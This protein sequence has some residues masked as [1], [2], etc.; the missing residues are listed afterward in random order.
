MSNVIWLCLSLFMVTKI[1]AM[2]NAR[3]LKLLKNIS[4]HQEQLNRSLLKAAS[5]GEYLKD[6]LHYAKIGEKNT[7]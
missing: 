7:K 3:D 5:Y 6:I 4:E 1:T 2:N